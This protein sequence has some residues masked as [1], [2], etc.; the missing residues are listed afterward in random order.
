MTPE[1]KFLEKIEKHRE[2]MSFIRKELKTEE[3]FLV[4]FNN[5]LILLEFCLEAHRGYQGKVANFDDCV[6]VYDE[7]QEIV[8]QLFESINLMKFLKKDYA[9]NT[10]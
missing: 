9:K 3:D 1:Q 4:F 8:M 2:K 7:I 5:T 6:V 10:T